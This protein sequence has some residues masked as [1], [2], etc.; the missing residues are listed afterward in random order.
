MKEDMYVILLDLL[1]ET[2]EESYTEW[3]YTLFY[4][5]GWHNLDILNQ[6]MNFQR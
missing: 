3:R 1:L 4:K 6:I 5:R 2:G